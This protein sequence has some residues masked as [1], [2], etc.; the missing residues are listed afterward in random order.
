MAGSEIASEV[1]TSTRHRS[2]SLFE[3]CALLAQDLSIRDCLVLESPRTHVANC[4]REQSVQ[5]KASEVS[6][7]KSLIALWEVM[8]SFAFILRE[9]GKC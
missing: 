7:A 1:A 3:R 6:G 5:C 2:F 9:V 8:G 4:E